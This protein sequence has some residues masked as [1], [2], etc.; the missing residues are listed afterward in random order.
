MTRHA[1]AHVIAAIAGNILFW[2]TACTDLFHSTDFPTLC[3]VSD[4]APACT[5]DALAESSAGPLCET[6]SAKA[7]KLATSTCAKLSACSAVTGQWNV[8]TCIHDASLAY[9]CN[10]SAQLAPRGVRAELWRCVRYAADCAAIRQ[11]LLGAPTLPTCSASGKDYASCATDGVRVLCGAAGGQPIAIESCFAQGRTCVDGRCGGGAKVCT[12]SG[13]DGTALH[14]CV[15]D[16]TGA[17]SDVGFD[18]AL[19]GDGRCRGAG[20]AS[21][22]APSGGASCTSTT[23]VRCEN[24]IAI[25]CLGGTEQRVSCS[26]LGL[27]CVGGEVTA[28]GVVSA[29]K[30]DTDCPVDTC[31]GSSIQTCARRLTRTL[32]CA[33]EGY[34]PCV[35][36][37]VAGD[38]LARCS[39]KR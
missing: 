22:C 4:A 33:G 23:G 32:D 13:C 8:A 20:A 24:G 5:T 3:E 26:A 37:T 34:G 19:T 31:N 15:A 30:G 27:P 39:P 10:G 29:C 6:N 36:Q 38:V 16:G 35:V 14:A 18:C 11:C 25:G 28:E 2:S 17:V 1:G 21:F 7:A 9:D 12:E